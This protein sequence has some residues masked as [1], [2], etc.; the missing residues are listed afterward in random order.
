VEVEMRVLGVLVRAGKAPEA[1]CLH[2]TNGGSRSRGA[3]GVAQDGRR[4]APIW[5]RFGPARKGSI[6]RLPQQP[7]EGRPRPPRR[8]QNMCSHSRRR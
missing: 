4:S 8:P 2:R 6:T 1:G 5:G 3:V 7:P